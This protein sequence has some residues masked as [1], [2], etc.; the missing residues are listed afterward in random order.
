MIVGIAAQS[1]LGNLFAGLQIAFTDAI[2]ID[3][4]VVVQGQRGRIEEITLT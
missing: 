4:I 1:T 3:D 2:R